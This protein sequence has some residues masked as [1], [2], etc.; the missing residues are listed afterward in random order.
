MIKERAG[1]AVKQLSG[2]LAYYS[3]HPSKLP[4][5]PEIEID[6]ELTEKLIKAYRVLA[7]LDDRAMHIANIELF[8]SM[9]VQKEALLSSQ[10]EGTQASISDAIEALNIERRNDLPQDVD[11][12][13]HY[14][15]ALN[16]GLE[17]AK[18]F[19]FSLRFIM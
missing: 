6:R 14:I 5:I 4:P 8:I 7:I 19:P 2:K 16:Y 17:R 10:I 9:Y 18:D 15:E 12:I 11:D 1:K 3:F 13:L